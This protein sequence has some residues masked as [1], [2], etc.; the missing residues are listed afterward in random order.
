MDKRLLKFMKE[1]R[2]LM[3]KHEGIELEGGDH[4]GS[5]GMG[6]DIN[7]LDDQRVLIDSVQLGTEYLRWCD[8]IT[9]ASLTKDI[10]AEDNE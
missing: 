1:L 9:A 3:E 8:V 4:C 6:M 7:L 2:D 5:S 10:K